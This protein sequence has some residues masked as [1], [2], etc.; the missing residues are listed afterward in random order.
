MKILDNAFGIHERA[1]A[2]RNRRVELI[3]QNIANADTPNYKARDIDFKAALERRLAGLVDDR[4]SL[5]LQMT[6]AR[7]IQVDQR[8]LGDGYRLFRTP[9]QPSVDGNTVDPDLER[10]HF[11]KNAMYLESTLAFLNSTI[12]TRLTAITGQM[13]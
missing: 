7:H 10:S 11:V 2:V 12:K 1:L 4:Q 5:S 9:V 3:S 8:A 6:D 13:S